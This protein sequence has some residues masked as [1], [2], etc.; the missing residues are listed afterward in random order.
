MAP[1]TPS[2]CS[3]QKNRLWAFQVSTDVA[4][5]EDLFPG[6][7]ETFVLTLV[8]DVGGDVDGA[9]GQVHLDEVEVLVLRQ[10]EVRAQLLR[11][12]VG[13][14]QT[15]SGSENISLPQVHHTRG[16]GSKRNGRFQR[17]AAV[18]LTQSKGYAKA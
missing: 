4:E 9:A 10:V 1:Q 18:I 3:V 7:K 13:H 14:L 6:Q 15:A 8:V 5:L 16:S 2:I 12:R 17:F 11:L